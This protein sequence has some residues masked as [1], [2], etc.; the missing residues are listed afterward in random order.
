MAVVADAADE[1]VG[2]LDGPKGRQHNV[3]WS[4]EDLSHQLAATQ[5]HHLRHPRGHTARHLD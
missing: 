5:R 1:D 4:P 2:H 3:V